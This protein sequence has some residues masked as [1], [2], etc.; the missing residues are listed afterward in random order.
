MDEMLFETID[1]AFQ[2]AK[3]KGQEVLVVNELEGLA[4]PNCKEFPRTILLY[5][6]P[7]E[8]HETF[9]TSWWSWFEVVECCGCGAIYSFWNGT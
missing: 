5:A 2:Y 1:G 8:Y 4:C 9:S 7:P 3:E 6:D